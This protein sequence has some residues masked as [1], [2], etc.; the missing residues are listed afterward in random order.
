VAKRQGCTLRFI[1]Q[2]ERIVP[3][4][5]KS[6]P[7]LEDGAYVTTVNGARKRLGGK[8]RDLI[9]ELIRTGE[10]HSYLD[11]R[12][13]LITTASIKAYVERKLAAAKTFERAR[14]PGIESGRAPP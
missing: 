4:S 3:A 9:Y 6:Q 1:K 8:S 5:N 12:R 13:R 11:G 10:L 2:P 14:F 7:T